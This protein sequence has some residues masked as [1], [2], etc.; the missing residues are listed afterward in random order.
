[1]RWRPPSLLNPIH[2]EMMREGHFTVEVNLELD[3]DRMT[4][5]LLDYLP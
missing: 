5:V 3:G 1:M 2:E 4:N